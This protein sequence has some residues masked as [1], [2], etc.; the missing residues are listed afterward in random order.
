MNKEWYEKVKEDKD[1]VSYVGPKQLFNIMGLL[2]A[3]LL[4]ELGL[5]KK[6]RVLDVGCGSLR[7]GRCLMHECEYHGIEPER[8]VLQ[9]AAKDI[10]A[11]IEKYNPTF[12]HDFKNVKQEF[13]FVIMHSI[14][15]H[16]PIP[17]FID[18]LEKIKKITH[19]NSI[20]IL[21]YVPGENYMGREWVYP[22]HVTYK[23]DFIK[24][25]CKSCLFNVEEIEWPH[26]TQKWL[27]LKG[28][29]C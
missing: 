15:S 14:L 13:D 26:T 5:R 9:E 1:Y 2:Q 24:N 20:V 29:K 21:T 23:L 27:L 17:M 12:Y 19:D 4:K 8:W 3:Q 16:M 25:I 22:S 7:A 11:Y 28:M 10:S 18:Y 6:H